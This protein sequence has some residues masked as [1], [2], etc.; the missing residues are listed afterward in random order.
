MM[1]NKE[2]KTKRVPKIGKPRESN[3]EMELLEVLLRVLSSTLDYERLTLCTAEIL[4]RMYGF[5]SVA[6]YQYQNKKKNFEMVSI[7]GNPHWLKAELNVRKSSFLKD[8]Q[9]GEVDF[10]EA[11][12]TVLQEGREYEGSFLS[13]P[14]ID[15][16]DTRGLIIILTDSGVFDS[17]NWKSLRL[18]SS[19]LSSAIH[20]AK[21]FRRIDEQLEKKVVQ[22]QTLKEVTLSLISELNLEKLFKLIVEESKRIFDA[23]V[24]ELS[25]MEGERKINVLSREGLLEGGAEEEQLELAKLLSK[26]KKK[27][28]DRIFG[29]KLLD[30]LSK[31]A[32]ALTIPI[33]FSGRFLGALILY[34]EKSGGS[35][36]RDEKIFAETFGNLVSSAINN[37]INYELLQ[38]KSL[39][40]KEKS[41]EFEAV[42]ESIRDAIFIV[43]GEKVIRS[44]NEK[45]TEML[46]IDRENA[47]GQKCFDIM[48]CRTFDGE[49]HCGDC[50]IEMLTE[51]GDSLDVMIERRDGQYVPVTVKYS[52]LENIDDSDSHVIVLRD[53]SKELAAER[54]LRKADRLATMGKLAA[55]WAHDTRN[56]LNVI[57]GFS[58][59]LEGSA[60]DE[61]VEII[62]MIK[63]QISLCNQ[64]ISDFLSFARPTQ[65]KRRSDPCHINGVLKEYLKEISPATLSRV[66]LAVELR[67][68]EDLVILDENEVRHVLQNILENSLTAIPGAGRLAI[69]AHNEG[70]NLVLS[71]SDSGV[72]IPE[73]IRDR[74]FEPFF[75]TKERGTGLGLSIVKQT[76]ADAGGKVEITSEAGEG[77]EVRMTIPLA[78]GSD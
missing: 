66:E 15:Q 35:F 22:M 69:S 1:K 44:V 20:N 7:S 29:A 45:W 65:K 4:K 34:R 25:F 53:I 11:R 55:A 59:I 50:F 71:V 78:K 43:N 73:K 46:G 49:T 48:K 24:V 31:D 51:M 28:K 12:K 14:V 2:L 8:L 74:V 57:S 33:V 37:S 16:N 60:S 27:G 58:E 52:R 6:Y 23:D 47:L 10:S 36:T 5:T 17:I 70:Q 21:L 63:E 76:L 62:K 68:K 56:P 3:P 54:E 42:F 75:T 13:L 61:Q 18:I 9:M 40:L 26:I 72:G 39:E 77:T 64:R 38:R 19:Q 67:S 30:R 41:E 32:T